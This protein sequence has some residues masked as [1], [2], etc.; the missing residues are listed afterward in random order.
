MVKEATKPAATAKEAWRT[1]QNSTIYAPLLRWRPFPVANSSGLAWIKVLA[2]NRETGA[3]TA[4]IKFDPGFKAPASTA[5]W[6][7]DIYVLEGEM[8]AGNRKYQEGT[9]HY[10]PRGAKVGPIETSQGC[11]RLIFTSETKEKSSPNEVWVQDTKVFPWSKSYSDPT[12]TT[13]MLKDLR[14]D[15]IAN[16]SVLI[17]SSFVPGLRAVQGNMHAHNHLE[18][19]YVLKGEFHDFLEEVDTHIISVPGVYVCRPPYQ[20]MHGDTLSIQSPGMTFVRRGWV[21]KADT[22]YD[23]LQEHSPDH[24]IVPIAFVE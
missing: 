16:M 6:P 19:Y 8:T 13:R 17:H 15:P 14:Q 9:Y 18:E 22:F 3:K 11:T 21:G 23:N 10:R 20:S 1:T 4:L 12:G 5:E 24:K 2:K 7:M